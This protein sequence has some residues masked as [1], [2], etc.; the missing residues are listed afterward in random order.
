VLFGKGFYPMVQQAYAD[1]LAT[2]AEWQD[3]SAEAQGG[4]AETEA[5]GD[6]AETVGAHR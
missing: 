1:R 6:D 3:L 2:W 4:D 5:R